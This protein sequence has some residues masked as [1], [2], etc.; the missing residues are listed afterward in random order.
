MAAARDA[1]HAAVKADHLADLWREAIK[2]FQRS[3]S[4]PPLAVIGEITF[5]TLNKVRQVS[6]F[7][8]L[9]QSVVVVVVVV[10]A[11][12]IQK[13]TSLAKNRIS[14]LLVV[15]VTTFCKALGNFYR[16]EGNA[17]LKE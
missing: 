3:P 2:D 16:N 13:G 4:C 11:A 9:S 10:V 7:F 6:T 5:V 14:P 15:F 1:K 17:A 12:L 8:F